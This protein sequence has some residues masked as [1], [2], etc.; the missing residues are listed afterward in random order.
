MK[1]DKNV[2]IT[3]KR[4]FS[5]KRIEKIVRI[6]TTALI[7]ASVLV[8]AT[9]QTAYASTFTITST[10]DDADANPGNGLCATGGGVCTL[11]AAI[12]E[13]NAIG[14]PD[15]IEF[16]LPV[17]INYEIFID[18]PLPAI[19]DQL[20]IDGTSQG[21]WVQIIDN[22]SG[23]DG[24]TIQDSSNS[25]IKGLIIIG[26]P[27][28]GIVIEDT[29]PVDV[30]PTANN[31]VTGNYIGMLKDGDT[32]DANGAGIRVINATNTSI[33]DNL[34]SGNTGDGIVVSSTAS[35]AYA[36]GTTIT[37][38]IVG[39][40]LAKDTAVANGG[41]GI[42]VD[43]APNTIIGGGSAAERNYLSG[44]GGS[45]VV[46][47]N[48]SDATS[49]T[50]NYIGLGDLGEVIF[51]NG[52]SGVEL[53]AA[54]SV[55]VGGTRNL[56]SGNGTYGVNIINGTTT[57][58][59]TGN[60][61]G[62]DVDGNEDLG[63][64]S[65]GVRI[66]GS[67][68]NTVSSNV[69]ANN[70]GSGVYLSGSADTNTIQSNQIG[71]S[72][73]GGLALGNGGHGIYITGSN[74]NKV[75]TNTI[76]NNSSDGV[77]IVGAGT[78]GNAIMSNT[79]TTN[80]G[81]GIDLGN[82]G[83]TTND[84]DDVDAGANTE[85]NTPVIT[86]VIEVAGGI[87]VTLNY[88]SAISIN[89]RFEFFVNSSCDASGYGEGETVIGTVDISTDINGL[90][91]DTIT[92]STGAVSAGNFITSVATYNQGV[93]G[94]K[95]SSEFSACE[96]VQPLA[97]G[98]SSG[99][100]VVNDTGDAVDAVPGDGFCATGG[101]VCTLRAA[102][103]EANA[104]G[105][106][107]YTIAFNISGVSPFT[108]SPGSTLPAIST[109]VIIDGSSQPGYGGSPL[110]VLDGVGATA[111]PGLDITSGGSGSTIRGL[112]VI[113]FST[114]YGIRL[115]NSTGNTVQANYIGIEPDGTVASNANGL[116]LQSASSNIIGGSAGNG[117]VISGNVSGLW[118]NSAN[119]NT[120]I[121]NYI[122]TD[123]TGTIDVGNLTQGL[124][125]SGSS[126]NIIGGNGANDGNVISGNNTNGVE[127]T[128]GS[129]ANILTGNKIGT[130][131]NGT[132]A[133]KNNSVGVLLNNASQN[134]LSSNTIAFNGGNGIT[135]STGD[136]NLFSQNSIFSN[137]SLGIDLGNDSLTANDAGDADGGAND[138]QNYPVFTLAA[139]G[140][141]YTYIEGTLN[142]T[143]NTVISLE[144]FSSPTGDATGFGEGK[145]YLGTMDVATDGSGDAVFT[146]S[147]GSAL[148]LGTVITG[149]G[150]D[151]AQNTSEFSQYIVVFGTAP[152]LTPTMTFT[153]PNTATPLPTNTPVNTAVPATNTPVPGPASTSTPTKTPTITPTPTLLGPYMTLTA[154]YS[155]PTE[156]LTGSE[157]VT[158]TVTTTSASGFTTATPSPTFDPTTEGIGGGGDV[159]FTPDSAAMTSEAF[160]TELAMT[161]EA[162]EAALAEQT[163]LAAGGGGDPDGVG[164]GDGGDPETP[165][166]DSGTNRLILWGCIGLALLLLLAGG[167]MELMRWMNSREE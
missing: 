150:I 92:V 60:Y 155:T 130:Q 5:P 26:F 36:D 8:S 69:I 94:F 10:A 78:V 53:D 2:F 23:G 143:A 48:G 15:L 125:I 167:G 154:L 149:V 122:G 162:G 165:V 25:V 134:I 164:G 111:G 41:D 93:G 139:P 133:L 47:A 98:G 64:T 100:F 83:V 62:L 27:G 59:V 151:P 28:D 80:D 112:S 153:P 29:A 99:V 7:L 3:L 136:Q 90:Y 75:L 89:Y 146:F 72:D 123:A 13:S 126:N 160:K 55:T 9:P 137:T 152:T 91:S 39:L 144:F 124:L 147:Y 73:G 159:T 110:I 4:L 96:V 16:N 43:D 76:K 40:N 108:I 131:L 6:F 58:S 166:E 129:S 128:G 56:I 135:V 51:A 138:L 81:L 71:Q 157:T 42:S 87:D 61:I 158:V 17:A 163:A 97:G 68:L 24:I 50:G 54:V 52:A 33:T 30:T 103:E 114:G 88:D 105:A 85:L 115:F 11:R 104:G 127:L 38:N 45:G 31:S 116:V 119:G 70:G 118:L 102:I 86:N 95:E 107:P 145:T 1:F 84:V 37:G 35:G 65:H 12:E 44:N 49:V 46:V 22:A 148:S 142:S 32:A 117:N 121:G 34:I 140:D 57:S 18:S 106:P 101:A 132:A 20:E 82:N 74:D 156:T 113:N 67:T 66:N 19:I 21:D 77:S 109:P 14:G 120:V 79:I 141:T 63:N 161:I